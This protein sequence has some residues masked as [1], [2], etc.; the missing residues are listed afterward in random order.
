MDKPNYVRFEVFQ[1]AWISW[2][3]LFQSAADFATRLGPG[4]LIGISHSHDSTTG[5]V[6]V[7]YWSDRPAPR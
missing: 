3:E 7:W 6:T 1:S 5:T 2:D 4:L